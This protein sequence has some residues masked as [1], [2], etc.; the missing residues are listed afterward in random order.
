[1]ANFG[2]VK[3]LQKFA[4]VRTLIYNH[5]NPSRHLVPRDIHKRSRSAAPE[6]L[7]GLLA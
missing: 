5:F 4:S 1:M 2:N 6:E 3:T 7:D